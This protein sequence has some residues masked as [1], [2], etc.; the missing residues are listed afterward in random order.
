MNKT[1]KL[2]QGAML[3]AII[4]ALML[5][6]RQLSYFFSTFIILMVPIVIAIYS[7]MYE[8]K[9]GGILC[10]GLLALALLLGDLYSYVYMPISIVVGLGVSYAIKKNWDRRRINL[11]AMVLYLIS[12]LV[13]VFLVYPLL[14]TSVDSQVAALKESYNMI[15]NMMGSYSNSFT[16]LIGNTS[17]FLLVMLVASTILMGVL[18]GFMTGFLTAVLLKRLKIKDI[19]MNTI[20][21]LKMPVYMAYLL[22]LLTALYYI[23]AKVPNFYTNNEILSY[24][25]MC[26]SS[27]SS[28]VL[29]YYGY[30]FCIIY[31]A[32]RWGKRTSIILILLIVLLFPYSFIILLLLGFLYGAGPL[33]NYIEKH[34]IINKQ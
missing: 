21:D 15:T 10:V 32:G 20:L 22:L 34:I 5:I 13:V 11:V 17:N 29:A 18:E 3:L 4:G 24:V 28:L 14:G 23:L 27:M 9:D 33:R 8:I 26:L 12:E 1:K 2:T 31:F 6:D 7:T 30:I 16:S 19:G 25:L